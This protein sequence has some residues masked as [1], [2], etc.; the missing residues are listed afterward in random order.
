MRSVK[1]VMLHFIQEYGLFSLA[2][3]SADDNQAVIRF[4]SSCRN[5]GTNLSSGNLV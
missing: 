3:E 4:T 1:Y 5:D 2:L